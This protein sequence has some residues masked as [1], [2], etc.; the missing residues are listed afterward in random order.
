MEDIV[1]ELNRAHLDLK[2]HATEMKKKDKLIS[3]MREHVLEVKTMLKKLAGKC[4]ALEYA[5]NSQHMEL[6]ETQTEIKHLEE[7]LFLAKEAKSAMEKQ[8]ENIV[9]ANI[10]LSQ[11]A[12][13]EGS[14]DSD[15]AHEKSSVGM[16]N[17]QQEALS[18]VNNNMIAGEQSIIEGETPQIDMVT[19]VVFEELLHDFDQ[20]QGDY[21]VQA[22]RLEELEVQLHEDQARRE[23]DVPEQDRGE[24]DMDLSIEGVHMTPKELHESYLRQ[25]TEHEDSMKDMTISLRIKDKMI[26]DQNNAI[27]RLKER[28]REDETRVQETITLLEDDNEEIRNDLMQLEEQL[29]QSREQEKHCLKE[30]QDMEQDRNAYQDKCKMNANEEIK[31]YRAAIQEKDD[32]L[33][34]ARIELASICEVVAEMQSQGLKKDHELK[35][36]KKKLE[37]VSE[38]VL[39]ETNKYMKEKTAKAH[40]LKDV[41]KMRSEISQSRINKEDVIKDLKKSLKSKKIL[42]LESHEKILHMEQLFGTFQQLAAT[43]SAPPLTSRHVPSQLPQQQQQLQPP[44]SRPVSMIQGNYSLPIPSHLL[45]TE[46]ALAHTIEKYNDANKG[47]KESI[48]DM[49]VVSSDSD[50]D[51]QQNYNENLHNRHVHNTTRQKPKNTSKRRHKSPAASGKPL[52][53]MPA[54]AKSAKPILQSKSPDRSNIPSTKKQQNP[55]LHQ[56]NTNPDGSLAIFLPHSELPSSSHRHSA[57]RSYTDVELSATNSATILELS[58]SDDDDSS[59]RS[60]LQHQQ[61][62]LF[63]ARDEDENDEKDNVSSVNS[64]Q[65]LIANSDWYDTNEGNRIQDGNA[66]NGHDD[67]RSRRGDEE[68]HMGAGAESRDEQH[69][70]N[71][72]ARKDYYFEDDNAA[73]TPSGMSFH[74]QFYERYHDD[75]NVPIT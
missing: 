7:E 10:L 9:S 62:T 35:Q 19:R 36:F 28:H 11:K 40:L 45:L 49:S 15:S 53:K 47:L 65:Q 17:H 13:E 23:G 68:K 5:N 4:H 26:D 55:F 44:G 32:A 37:N 70:R 33:E 42:L 21:D 1:S 34:R 52:N 2:K 56:T 25:Q 46:G 43:L 51:D 67:G 64:N 29:D 16:S 54:A 73:T 48:S 66:E 57:G 31:P 72:N 61:G 60:A 20:L 59:F 12:H 30:L 50:N 75:D 8:R 39:K 18:V 41:Q 24:V 71:N 63:S 22:E 14:S 69:D 74:D 38:E 6:E 58:R 27:R 3:E